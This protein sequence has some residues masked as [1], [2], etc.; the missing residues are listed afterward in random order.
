MTQDAAEMARL[1]NHVLKENFAWDWDSHVG[2]KS[3]DWVLR[4]RIIDQDTLLLLLATG[5]HHD[6]LK[7]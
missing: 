5:T 1:G 6:T 7:R 2:Q 3:S 4:Y